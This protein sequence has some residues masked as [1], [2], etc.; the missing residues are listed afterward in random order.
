M[1]SFWLKKKQ[2]SVLGN[3]GKK[4]TEETHTSPQAGCHLS[5]QSLRGA[6]LGTTNHICAYSLKYQSIDKE[7]NLNERAWKSKDS[8]RKVPY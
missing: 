8:G 1:L 6:V 5:P 2:H 4:N 7:M 3:R